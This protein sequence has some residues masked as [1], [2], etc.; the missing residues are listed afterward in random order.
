MIGKRAT[1]NGQVITEATDEA[2]M[3]PPG[4]DNLV[5]SEIKSL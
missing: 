5:C 1:S 2:E 4:A 3:M